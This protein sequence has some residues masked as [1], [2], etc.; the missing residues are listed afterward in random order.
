[1]K[2]IASTIIGFTMTLAAA[3]MSFAAQ[4]P[5]ATPAAGSTSTP[6][7]VAKKHTKKHSTKPATTSTPD[8]KPAPASK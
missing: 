5:A 2:T 1:M 6:A 8:A 7:P 3:G 4:A